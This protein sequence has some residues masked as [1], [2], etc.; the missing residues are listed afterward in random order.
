MKKS[1]AGFGYEMCIR[2]RDCTYIAVGSP[3][4]NN[5]MLPT[6]ASFL[7]YLKGLS[8]KNRKAFAFGSYGWGGQ[9]IGLVEDELKA[10]GFDICLDKIRIQYVPKEEQLL[11]ITEK[12]KNL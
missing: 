3:T 9:S 1:N 10:C 12:V 11:E 4:L 2:D 8:P 5:Q 7:C 6:V